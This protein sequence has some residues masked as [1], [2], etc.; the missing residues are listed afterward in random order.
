[1]EK[2]II[3]RPRL[4]QKMGD[5]QAHKATFLIAPAG[6]GKTVAMAQLTAAIGQPVVWY[7]I[8]SY[9]NDPAIF[10]QYLIGFTTIFSKLWRTAFAIIGTG[11]C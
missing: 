5:I 6:Y 3:E 7:Q 2:G 11:K 10:L 4:L 9:D 1:M 8:D